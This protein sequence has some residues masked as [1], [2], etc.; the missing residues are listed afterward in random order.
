MKRVIKMAPED[1]VATAL[2]KLEVGDEIKVVSEKGGVVDTF[3][4]L[5]PIVFGHKI[6]L[7]TIAEGSKVI[8]YGEYIGEATQLINRGDHVHIHNLKSLRIPIPEK[9]LEEVRM[10]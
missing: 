3:R 6:A 4:T 2:E 7:A 8:K 10:E 9:V 1:N 5:Q